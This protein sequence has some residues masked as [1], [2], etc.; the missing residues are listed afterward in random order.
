MLDMVF[1]ETEKILAALERLF[2]REAQFNGE[3][4][5]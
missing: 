2:L 3:C 4:P 5:Q 1:V